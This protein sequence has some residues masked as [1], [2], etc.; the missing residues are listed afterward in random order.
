VPWEQLHSN[1]PED[2][3]YIDTWFLP[4]PSLK[5]FL[6]TLKNPHNKPQMKFALKKDQKYAAIACI[7]GHG[8]HFVD[9]RIVDRDNVCDVYTGDFGSSYANNTGIAGERFFTGNPKSKVADIEIFKI[10]D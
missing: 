1:H 7:P 5:S 9:F 2:L 10:T 6:F 3:Y 8:P 4:D